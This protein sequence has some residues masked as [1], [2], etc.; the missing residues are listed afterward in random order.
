MIVGY[1]YVLNT[2]MLNFFYVFSMYL[3][4]SGSCP[5]LASENV[6]RHGCGTLYFK[7]N[8]ELGQHK[9][10]IRCVNFELNP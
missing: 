9:V 2:S 10:A 3:R 1:G 7:E 8:K 6:F 5:I 4:G